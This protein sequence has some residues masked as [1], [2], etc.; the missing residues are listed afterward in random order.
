VARAAMLAAAVPAQA[1]RYWSIW[2]LG[3]AGTCA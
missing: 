1:L 2:T 3:T